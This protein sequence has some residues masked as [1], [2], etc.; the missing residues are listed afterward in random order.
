MASIF[1]D[2]V[3]KSYPGGQQALTEV[4]FKLESG[5]MTFLTGHSGAGKTTLMKLIMMLEHPSQ[6]QVFV[7][8]QNLSRLSARQIPFHRRKIGVVFQNHQL[9]FDRNVFDNVALPLFIH[10]Y[11]PSEIKR[12][13]H[14]VLD[15][16]DLRHRAKQNPIQLSGGEQQRVGIARAVVHKPDILLADEPTGNL[17]RKLAAEIMTL[18]ERFNAVGVTLLIATHNIELVQQFN[19]QEL[20]LNKGQLARFIPPY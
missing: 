3:S 1:F 19:K 11:K 15:K 9:L 20:Q 6:G 16:V 4:Q 12:R 17:D 8:S 14:T 13:V 10:G 18:F 7:D 5:S 2:N